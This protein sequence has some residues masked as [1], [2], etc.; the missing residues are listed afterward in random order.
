MRVLEM[1]IF[2]NRKPE[3]VAVFSMIT[4]S[5]DSEVLQERVIL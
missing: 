3:E 2:K 4:S 1:Y 5:P